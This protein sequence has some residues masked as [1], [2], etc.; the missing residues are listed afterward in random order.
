MK[1]DSISINLNITI[2]KPKITWESFIVCIMCIFMIRPYLV[3]TYETIDTLWAYMTMF[4]FLISIFPILFR[5][6]TIKAN[7]FLFIYCLIY[8]YATY[9]Y[10]RENLSGAISSVGQILLAADVGLYVY[11]AKDKQNVLRTMR[12]VFLCYLYI[13]AIWGLLNIGAYLDWDDAMT[14]LSY[15]NYAVYFII[16]MMSSIFLIDLYV[17]GRIRPKDWCCYA[18]CLCYKLYTLS[19]NAVI[20]LIVY[21][22]LYVVMKHFKT[23]QK[24]LSVRNV[25]ILLALVWIGVTFFNIHEFLNPIMEALGK[26]TDLNGRVYIWER[27]SSAFA[28]IPLYGYGKLDVGDFQAITGIPWYDVQFDHAH[29]LLAQLFMDTGI[30]GFIMY[31]IWLGNSTYRLKSISSTP[32]RSLALSSLVTYLLAGFIDGYPWTPMFYVYTGIVW[33]ISKEAYDQQEVTESEA[34]PVETG[35]LVPETA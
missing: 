30:L 27:F 14:F 18:L 16:P 3:Q 5:K 9:A 34:V 11:I 33:S 4:C 26:G 24:I 32:L 22:I 15:D 21:V 10:Q 8:L 23:V 17:E 25:V 12:S 20:F 1:Q 19:L 35:E 13:D 6:S 31:M 7:L 2:H 28:D 29:N